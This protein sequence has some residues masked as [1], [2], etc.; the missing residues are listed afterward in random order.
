MGGALWELWGKLI[1]SE[2]LFLSLPTPLE[3]AGSAMLS[4]GLWRGLG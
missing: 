1:L 4:G 2:L 3:A